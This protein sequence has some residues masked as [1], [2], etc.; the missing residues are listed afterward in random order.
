[1]G[2]FSWLPFGKKKKFL[3][4]I[5]VYPNKRVEMKKID[6]NMPTF[7]INDGQMK[8][9]YVIDQKAIYFFNEEPL[10]F[11][12]SMSASPFLILDDSLDYTMSSS[13]FQSIIESKVVPELLEASK[14]GGWD[15]HFIASVVGAI[16][17]IL[18]LLNT[19]GLNFLNLGG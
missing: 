13:E 9:K 2:L 8:R 18:I 1:M 14:G 10:L 3:K 16:C 15:L 4:A 17:G 19:G 6:G 5:I 12:N 7:T 11:F